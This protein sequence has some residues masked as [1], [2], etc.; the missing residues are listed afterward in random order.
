MIAKAPTHPLITQRRGRG[1]A[2]DEALAAPRRCAEERLQAASFHLDKI[3]WRQWVKPGG[4]WLTRGRTRADGPALCVRSCS[5]LRVS[6]FLNRMKK[7]ATEPSSDFNINYIIRQIEQMKGGPGTNE[8]H[9]MLQVQTSDASDA[10]GARQ[11]QLLRDTSEAIGVVAAVARLS[12]YYPPYNQGQLIVEF[13]AIYISPDGQDE[14][15]AATHGDGG[16]AG[17]WRS[18]KLAEALVHFA[19]ED[20]REQ[21]EQ[22]EPTEQMGF[23]PWTED[24]LERMQARVELPHCMQTAKDFWN[25]VGFSIGEEVDRVESKIAIL[26]GLDDLNLTRLAQPPTLVVS[27]DEWH[28]SVH[29]RTPSSACSV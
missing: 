12:R 16:G 11:P 1:Q 18:K 24:R 17:S 4:V 13:R 27:L 19:L 20:V 25:K 15:L 22:M 3:R 7:E 2:R 28:K 5:W 9:V 26:R 6:D 8:L 23:V 21:M 10:D 29:S 14:R